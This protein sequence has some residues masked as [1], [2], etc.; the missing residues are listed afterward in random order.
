MEHQDFWGGLVFLF[1][2]MERRGPPKDLL[3]SCI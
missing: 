3:P 2:M 1:C